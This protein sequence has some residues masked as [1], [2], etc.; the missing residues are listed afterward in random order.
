M[1]R[2]IRWFT[3]TAMLLFALPGNVQAV[4][5][6]PLY[7]HYDEPPFSVAIPGSLTDKLALYLSRQSEGRYSFTP[8]FIPRKRLEGDIMK[9]AD[10]KGATAWANPEF[11]IDPHQ[12]KY[13]WSVPFLQDVNLVLSNQIK[14]VNFQGVASLHGLTVGGVLGRVLSGF[15]DDIRTGKIKREDAP[16]NANNLKKLKF[17][18]I[19]AM[20]LSASALPFYHEQMPDLDKWLYVAQEPRNIMPRH[21]IVNPQAKELLNFLDS[22]LKKMQQ[23]PEWRVIIKQAK[24]WP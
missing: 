2:L 19:D 1:P 23:D 9:Q 18:H 4:E 6:L 10:W 17:G 8:T 5:I 11:F 14:P 12:D 20:F 21:L 7:S 15:E 24:Q 3:R 13:L 22:A 16:G